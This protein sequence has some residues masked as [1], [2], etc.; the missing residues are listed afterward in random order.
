MFGFTKRG[1]ITAATLALLSGTAA[2]ASNVH[3]KPPNS[4]PAFTDG[5]L[6]LS[7]TGTLAG[8]GNGDVLVD[9]TAEANP[10]GTCTNPGGGTQPP[11]QNPAPVQVTGSQAIPDSQIKNGTVSF[12]VVTNPPVTPVV[13][14]PDCPNP[15]WR[16]DITDMAFTSA[17]IAIRQ[18]AMPPPVVLTASCQFTSPTTNGSV[19]KGNVT[20]VIQ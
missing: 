5:G 6:I 9:L 19:P 1:V 8:L 14:A 15:Q 2:Y 20:C 13:G 12:N 18:G 4:Q 10:T 17:V 3:F 11:G 16:E 7:A